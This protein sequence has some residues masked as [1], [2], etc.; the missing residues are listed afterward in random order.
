MLVISFCSWRK[1]SSTVVNRIN[2]VVFNFAHGIIRN[3]RNFFEHI[4]SRF[5]TTQ[6]TMRHHLDGLLHS[7][8]WIHVA[9][10][11]FPICIV[12]ISTAFMREMRIP[13]AR[14]SRCE[15]KSLR[16]DALAWPHAWIHVAIDPFPICIVTISTALVAF[17]REMRIPCARAS[18]CEEK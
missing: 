16:S 8:A 14:A 9:I 2:R 12:T 4:N 5:N 1:K 15:E 11:P 17:M 6:Q 3:Q 7:H 18:R 13:C 10:D